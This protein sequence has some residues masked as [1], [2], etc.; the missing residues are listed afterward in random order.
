MAQAILTLNESLENRPAFYRA[1]EDE[2]LR[3]A[4]EWYDLYH[5]LILRDAEWNNGR[6][7]AVIRNEFA[8]TGFPVEKITI[9]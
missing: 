8:K 3:E 9:Q 5:A 1:D 4:I 2:K 7:R 6:G